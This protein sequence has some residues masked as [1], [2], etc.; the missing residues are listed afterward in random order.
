VHIR[1]TGHR[2]P[3]IPCPRMPSRSRDV[4]KFNIKCAAPLLRLNR[5]LWI[6]WM[7]CIQHMRDF[8]FAKKVRKIS[9][10]GK[11]TKMNGGC[12]RRART[13]ITA[14]EAV[15]S[16][17]FSCKRW[18][19]STPSRVPERTKIF[20]SPCIGSDYAFWVNAQCCM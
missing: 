5:Y 8:I 4:Q 9:L 12:E 6:V 14:K 20:A 15:T 13:C 3:P 16:S 11:T 7:T 17:C 19:N 2:M 10:R 1:F 18:I